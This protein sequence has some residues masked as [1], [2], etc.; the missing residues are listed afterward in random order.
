MYKEI[1]VVLLSAVKMGIG[2]I[3]LAF[4]YKFGTYKII[5][6]CSLGGSLGALSFLEISDRANRLLNKNLNKKPKRVFTK[7][8]RLLVKIKKY[9]GMW[10][11]AFITPLFLSFPV[12]C[13]I[14]IRYF[15]NK[16]K[17]QFALIVSVVF[18][19]SALAVFRNLF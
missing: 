16:L 15:S 12:G 3:P 4:L 18:W 8:N 17:I 6:L 19:A 2:G 11:I 5:L 13:F 1:S 10:G 14:L 9:G 7:A